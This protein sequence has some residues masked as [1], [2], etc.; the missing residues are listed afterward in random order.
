MGE[1]RA[2]QYQANR[3]ALIAGGAGARALRAAPSPSAAATHST[4]RPRLA[5]AAHFAASRRPGA[6]ADTIS[7]KRE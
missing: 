7:S 5:L 6:W 2:R 3:F 1:V 4:A